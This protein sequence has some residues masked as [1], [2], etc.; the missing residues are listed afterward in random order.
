V[1][2]TSITS[3]NLPLCSIPRQHRGTPPICRWSPESSPPP[4]ICRPPHDLDTRHLEQS[5][6]LRSTIT[7]RLSKVVALTPT[8]YL[9]LESAPYPTIGGSDASAPRNISRLAAACIPVLSFPDPS[10]PSAAPSRPAALTYPKS[11]QWLR[12]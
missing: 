12:K 9:P 3:R 8:P 11:E 7:F 6:P 4:T 5:Q 10:G 2:S 1:R